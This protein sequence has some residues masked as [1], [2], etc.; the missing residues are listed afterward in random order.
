MIVK[1][2]LEDK[3]IHSRFVS[4]NTDLSHLPNDEVTENIFV[5][6]MMRV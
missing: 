6:N 5:F 2:I 4:G 3:K 1:M